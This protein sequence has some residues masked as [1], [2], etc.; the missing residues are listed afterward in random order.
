MSN[1]FSEKEEKIL[2]TFEKT[3][4]KMTELEREKLL[5]FGEGILFVKEKEGKENKSA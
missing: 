3:I 5:S 4:P 2:K 1:V